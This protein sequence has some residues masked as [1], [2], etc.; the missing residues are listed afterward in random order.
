MT[1]SI[2]ANA[3][4]PANISPVGPPPAITTACSV[5]AIMVSTR[6]SLA[7]SP[8]PRATL[9]M[10]A[11]VHARRGGRAERSPPRQR[12]ATKRRGAAQLRQP[13]IGER[14]PAGSPRL[15]VSP[16]PR[17]QFASCGRVN[18]EVDAEDQDPQGEQDLHPGERLDGEEKHD[19]DDSSE[20]C[21][22]SREDAEPAP[23][24]C[25]HDCEGA[26]HAHRVDREHLVRGVSTE[27]PD[28]RRDRRGAIRFGLEQSA[29]ERCRDEEHRDE[30][31]SRAEE[32]GWR[33]TGPRPRRSDRA[34][35]R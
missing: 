20:Q 16:L 11:K 14:E 10:A 22:P 27:S 25:G 1:T 5:I 4:S 21:E 12:R 24:R 30:Q 2:P 28:F 9:R 35:H 29:G 17:S 6:R 13:N 31:Q 18:E 3:S 19:P 26:G 7:A 32:H 8:L 23:D 15:L 34:L 33:R